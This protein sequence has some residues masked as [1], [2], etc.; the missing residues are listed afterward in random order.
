MASTA[1]YNNKV[2]ILKKRSFAPSPTSL[3][4]Y[5]AICSFLSPST[6]TSNRN[7]LKRLKC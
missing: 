7:M 1:V 6:I 5:G 4:V 3:Q 2:T